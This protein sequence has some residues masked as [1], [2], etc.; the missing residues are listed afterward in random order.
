MDAS[1]ILIFTTVY[2]LAVIAPGPGIAAVVGRA[3]ATGGAGAGPFIGGFVVGDLIWFAAAAAGLSALAQ[4]AAAVLVMVKYLGAGYLLFLA[5]R[6]WTSKNVAAAAASGHDGA[7]SGRLFLASLALTLGNPKPMVFFLALLPTVI[8]LGALTAQDGLILS[9]VIAV[10]MPAI[11]GVY[12]L[13]AIRA[14]RLL[15]NRR[16]F[17][18]VNRTSAAVMAGAAVAVARS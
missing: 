15:V 1:G 4:T 8:D 11:L 3:L 7:S 18:I 13:A 10:V 14:R 2:A 6:M 9:G 5:Y 16:A 12:V 17:R